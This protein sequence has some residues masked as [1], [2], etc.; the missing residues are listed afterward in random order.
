MMGEYIARR[1]QGPRPKSNWDLMGR[2]KA[3]AL[4]LLSTVDEANSMQEVP[5]VVARYL[6]EH[7]LPPKAVCWPELAHLPWQSSG[8]TVK[9]RAARDD[10]LI[11]ITGAFCAIAETGTLMLLSGEDTYAVTSLLP[12]THIAIVKVA[13]I[14]TG[15]EDAW[16][17]LRSERATMPR[18]VNFVSGPSRTADIEQTITL[19]AHGPYRVHIIL[20]KDE[21]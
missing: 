17:L 2:F 15:M 9:P 18:A 20:V 5:S 16:E 13:R 7:E 21:G 3:C 6:S 8:L 10:D 11:G 4:D 14:V 12:E 1:A 19:G